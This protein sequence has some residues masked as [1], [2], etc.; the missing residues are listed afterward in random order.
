MKTKFLLSISILTFFFCSF[1]NAQVAELW[2][3]TKTGGD[4][5][6]NIYKVNSDGSGFGFVHQFEYLGG[7]RNYPAIDDFAGLTRVGGKLYGTTLQGGNYGWG[8]LFVY[9][10]LTGIQTKLLDF[11][12]RGFVSGKWPS[13]SLLL[14]PDGKLYGEANGGG[15]YGLGVLYSFDPATNVY[16]KLLDFNGTGGGTGPRGGLAMGPNGRIYGSCNMGGIH[17]NGTLW[18][19]DYVTASFL[20]I[21]DFNAQTTGATP[22]G[23]LVMAPNGKLY[24]SC[25]GYIGPYDQYGSYFCFDVSTST[26]TTVHDFDADGPSYLNG[27][28]PLSGLL[29]ASDG[30]LYGVDGACIIRINPAG[31][32]FTNLFTYSGFGGLARLTEGAN[33]MFYAVSQGSIGTIYSFNLN[34]LTTAPLYTL[35]SATGIEVSGQLVFSGSG[36]LYGLTRGGGANV[37]YGVI[38]SFNLATNTYTDVW[39]FQNWSDGTEPIAGVMKTSNG[40]VYGTTSKGGSGGRGTVFKY[41][42]CTDQ[43]TTICSFVSAA[44][45]PRTP[46]VQLNEAT[47]GKLYGVS[48]GGGPTNYGTIFSIDTSTNTMT[49]VNSWSST[50]SDFTKLVNHSNGLMYATVGSG[51]AGGDIL[52]SV[53]PTTNVYTSVYTFGSTINGYRASTTLLAAPNGKLYGAC[54][55]G[56]ANSKGTIYS[57]DPSTLAFVK[58][59]DLT[60]ASGW[61]INGPMVRAANGKFYGTAQQG[62]AN[63]FGTIFSFDPSNNNFTVL[64]DFGTTNGGAPRGPLYMDSNGNFFGTASYG[65]LYYEGVLFSFNPT[66]LV[67]TKLKDFNGVDGEIPLGE[68]T[69]VNAGLTVSS[70]TNVSCGGS[71]VT[72]TATG[73]VSYLWQPGNLS[74]ASVTVNPTSTT[75]YTVSGTTA[76][77]CTKTGYLT[78]QI[79]TADAGPDQTVCN[80]NGAVQLNAHPQN[81]GGANNYTFAWANNYGSSTASN[82]DEGWTVAVDQAGNVYTGGFYKGSVNFGSFNLSSVGGSYDAY[83]IKTSPAGVV[84]W[85]ISGGGSGS[86]AIRDI[87]IDANGDV[88]I[89]GSLCGNSTIGNLSYTADAGGQA[90]IAKFNNAGAGQWIR[91]M[92]GSTTD[93]GVS[94]DVN[95]ITGDIYM[96]GTYQ[97]TG[98][99]GT[100]TITSAS[101]TDYFLVKYSSAGTFQ[102]VRTATNTTWA[103]NV[104]GIAVDFSGN[105]IVAGSSAGSSVNFGSLTVNLNTLNGFVVKYNSSGIE[106]WANS[107]GGAGLCEA[108]SVA[109]DNHGDSYVTGYF[110][111]S[112]TFGTTTI[113]PVGGDDLFYLKYSSNGGQLWLKTAGSSGPD[114]GEGLAINPAGDNIL[115]TTW[116]ANNCNFGP[117]YVVS[118]PFAS[119]TTALIS[120]D[121]LGT[122]NWE[123]DDFTVLVLTQQAV[124]DQTGGAIYGAGYFDNSSNV[125]PFLLTPG[126]GTGRDALLYK[127]G[128]STPLTYT[129]TPSTYLNFTNIPN[130]ISTP[131]GSMTYT[132][133]I[134]NGSCS[135]SDVVTVTAGSNVNAGPDVSICNGDN[136]I[137]NATG[138]GGNFSWSPTTGLSASNI[139]NPSANPTVT[140]TYTVTSVSGT[141]TSSDVVVVT[142]N[143]MPTVSVSPTNLTTCAGS[144]TTL[145]ASGA[146]TYNWQPGNL[147]GTSVSVSPASSTTY[148][149]TG[150]S[151]GCSNTATAT[152]TT[153]PT[154]TV[155]YVQNPL[156]VCINW[157]PITLSAGSPAGGTYSGP[158]VTGNTFNPSAAGGGNKTIVYTYTDGNNCSASVSQIIYVDLCLGVQSVVDENG[159][160]LQP[161]PFTDKL[162]VTVGEKTTFTIYNALGQSVGTYELNAGQTEIPTE[163][164][165]GGIYVVEF[166]NASG[167]STKKVVKQ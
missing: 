114:R 100:S 78:V 112:S 18:Y 75:T 146:T 165:A 65:G 53:N 49:L 21:F 92:G 36:K 105:I 38:F 14:A 137:L 161:N 155:S 45:S 25:A 67:Y 82:S 77:G 101:Q 95:K 48:S 3:V 99:F 149:V 64:Y 167:V 79:M 44:P 133:T 61:V 88:V 39:D 130:P 72:L 30:M 56:G 54:F 46:C 41:N 26:F 63:G 85:A 32:V 154:P 29:L 113:L 107:L 97:N 81:L 98:T 131:V 42:T 125:G 109:V 23:P 143:P 6:G 62:G 142:V 126:G 33:G 20:K 111:G 31:N 52:Y 27:A 17:N 19:W 148:T 60:T 35:S 68:M 156:T 127:T 117:G 118:N 28:S 124:Y 66:T 138:G 128:Q 8:T 151:S 70:S 12:D 47:N 162:L 73:A 159:V 43:M 160:G 158:G 57:Y 136:T 102:W 96:D 40:Q 4:T 121:T 123:T 69:P 141:C 84:Q 89:T 34:T 157:S 13:G 110:N 166:K 76:S 1:S 134:S 50:K 80:G 58:L 164:L 37:P 153:N 15:Y 51:F 24:G 104:Y 74:G 140:T 139:P 22:I 122:Y 103:D 9:D 11:D 55:A 129:W 16:T 91:T 59:Y 132:V 120:S 144:P 108:L 115:L 71:P 87:V 106:Q 152:I 90:F 5:L 147:N 10:T 163:T 7:N 2:G 119:Q 94:I 83:L 145:T 150:T 116:V 93:I 86:D 135:V